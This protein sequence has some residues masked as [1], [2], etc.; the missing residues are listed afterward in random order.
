[1]IHI[2]YLSDMIPLCEEPSRLDGVGDF[3]VQD[4]MKHPEPVCKECGPLLAAHNK[5]EYEKEAYESMNIIQ[6]VD[7]EGEP[8]EFEKFLTG[9]LLASAFWITIFVIFWGVFLR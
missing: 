2:R 7:R 4:H 5:R 6:R 9:V 1:M 8:G 3:V